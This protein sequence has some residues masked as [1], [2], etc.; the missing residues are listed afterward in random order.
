MD[1]ESFESA[2]AGNFV[3]ARICNCI[4]VTLMI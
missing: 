4:A 2:V 1:T 3:I